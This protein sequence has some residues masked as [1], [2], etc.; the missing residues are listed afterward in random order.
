MEAVLE[1]GQHEGGKLTTGLILSLRRLDLLEQT[2]LQSSNS[3]GQHDDD[4]LR[5]V[6]LEITGGASGNESWTKEWRDQLLHLLLKLFSSAKTPDYTSITQI[7]IQLHEPKLAAKTLSSLMKEG[8]KLEAFQIAFDLADSATQRFMEKVVE[9][10]DEDEQLLEILRGDK[11]IRLYL[12]FLSKNNHSDL[13]ILKNTKEA[14]ESRYSIFHSAVTFANALAHAGT[15]S[16]KFLREN[17]DWLGKASNWSMFSATAALGVIH[18]GS[19]ARALTVMG[20]YLPQEAQSPYQ[21]GGALFGLGLIHAKHGKEVTGFLT[22][23]LSASPDEI[24]QHGAAL[25]LGVAGMASHNEETYDAL[26]DI[27]F[28]DSSV[29][30]EA[31]G[32]AMGLVMLGSGNERALEEMLQYAH[33]TQHEKIIRG[34]AIGIAFLQ[35]GRAEQADEVIDQLIA[36]KDSLLRYGAMFTLALAYAGTANNQAIRKL[37]HVAVSDANDDVRRAAV[38]SLGLVMFRNHTQV[39]RVV[40]L[41]SESYNPHVRHGATLALGISCASTGHADAIDLLEPMT[42]DPV[43]F[44][45]QGAF[46]A[47][48]MV[49]I[50]QNEAQSGSTRKMFERVVADKHEDSLAKFGAA[51]AQG[52]IDAGGRNVTLSMQSRAGT[53]NMTA[54]VGM[55]L[56]CQFWYWYPLAHCLSLSFTP[57]AIIG[58][59][60]DLKLPKVEFISHA[61][62]SLFAY[63]APWKAPVKETVE[64]APTAVLSTTARANARQKTKEKEKAVADGGMDVDSKPEEKPAAETEVKEKEKEQEQDQEIETEKKENEKKPET[65]IKAPEPSFEILENVSRVIPSQLPYIS[66]PSSGVFQ[67]VRPLSGIDA[68]QLPKKAAASKKQAGQTVSANELAHLASG[69]SNFAA[70]GGIIMLRRQPGKEDEPVEYI[71]LNDKLDRKPPQ[72][73]QSQSQDEMDIE[74]GSYAD[75]ED[76]QPEAEPPVAFEVSITMI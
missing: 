18:K 44:V 76:D 67:P 56:F 50:Q 46:I 47:L 22:E 37:L 71:E 63:P 65:E 31:C 23:Q 42:K 53:P 57:T 69:P 17:L 59:D 14:L 32:Y 55:T 20:P 51:I 6:L 68:S 36:E 16:D 2:Y 39:P 62:P 58:L 70:G 13:A 35:Y 19:L 60:E 45:R 4:I 75:G 15:T 27:L 33:E 24:I 66:F 52:I 30:G 1:N 26:R 29:A 5:Y 43:D 21:A 8:K 34:L 40:Q 12:E 38:T 64:K 28:Q 9:G 72:A 25:G 7:W 54:I 10:C 49:Q 11:S 61:K 73:S 48:A 3:E 74:R 41:L